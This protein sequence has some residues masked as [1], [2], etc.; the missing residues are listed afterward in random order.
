WLC[1][2]LG[3]LAGGVVATSHPRPIVIEEI[4]LDP[5]D[6]SDGR[7]I[8]VRLR[9]RND[10]TETTGWQRVSVSFRGDASQPVNFYDQPPLEPG[11]STEFASSLRAWVP[12]GAWTINATILQRS[13][14]TYSE[15]LSKSV[16]VRD[17]PA[18]RANLVASLFRATDA[19]VTRPS[20]INFS[21]NVENHGGAAAMPFQVRF[22]L[23]DTVFDTYNVTLV[24]DPGTTLVRGISQQSDPSTKRLSLRAGNFTARMVVD[25]DEAIEESTTVD[26]VRTFNFTILP[27]PAKVYVV[28]V[29]TNPTEPRANEPF[30]VQVVIENRGELKAP[31]SRMRVLLDDVPLAEVDV[32]EIPE[33]TIRV[34]AGE[35][36]LPAGQHSIGVDVDIDQDYPLRCTFLC[37]GAERWSRFLTI[38]ALPAPNSESASQ[39]EAA[40]RSEDREAPRDD[41]PPERSE[42]DS[43]ARDL[44]LPRQET[45]FPS[46]I[47]AVVAGL[48][49]AARRSAGRNVESGHPR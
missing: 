21:W 42:E 41:E 3:V 16:V 5:A 39:S 22:F 48:V 30:R 43:G 12:A 36:A 14:A 8:S 38:R 1:L 26:N 10:G 27:E 20:G 45:P 47:L 4:L 19:N 29:S 35:G 24:L 34:E 18:A 23:D 17:D 9:V 28:A 46:G 15:P 44:V 7:P 49:A 2:A 40:E 11:R 13:G 31:P 32:P 37:N 6:P 33:G 25:P